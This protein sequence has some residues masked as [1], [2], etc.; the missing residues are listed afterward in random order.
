MKLKELLIGDEGVDEDVDI[1]AVAGVFG[2]EEVEVVE[3]EVL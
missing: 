2:V 3:E 1:V